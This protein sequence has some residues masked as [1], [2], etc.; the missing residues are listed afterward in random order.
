MLCYAVQVGIAH[1]LCG[2]VGAM[3]PTGVFVRCIVE[4]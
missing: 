1:L 2:M 4:H 3:P